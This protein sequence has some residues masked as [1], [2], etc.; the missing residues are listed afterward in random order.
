MDVDAGKS[1]R[2]ERGR[3]WNEAEAGKRFEA[4]KRPWL[5]RIVSRMARERKMEWTR[6]A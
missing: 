6:E 2:L 3:G 4:G 1:W 5:E